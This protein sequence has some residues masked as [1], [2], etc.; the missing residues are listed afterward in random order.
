MITGIH[1]ISMKCASAE[2]Y[3]KAMHFYLEIL[4]L[5]VK[6]EWADGVMIDTGNA[7]LEIFN[8]GGDVKAKGII[9]HMAF[10][11]DD[12]DDMVK[13]LTQEGYEV[14][15][16]PKDI[17]IPSDPPYPARIAFCNGPLGEEIEFFNEK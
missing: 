4:G 2:E 9:A 7:L 1:H 11:C 14:F 3:E 17:E 13:R 16:G 5:K 12:V 15:M 6:R 10:A 8:S